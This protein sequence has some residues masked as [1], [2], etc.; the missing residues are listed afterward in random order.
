MEQKNY[1]REDGVINTG[2]WIRYTKNGEPFLNGSLSLG[3][4]DYWVNVF[5]V[6]P[7]NKKSPNSPDR[8]MKLTPKTESI[9]KPV[10]N[11]DS[12]QINDLIGGQDD[13][14]PF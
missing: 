9:Q 6:D 12:T 11:T 3:G 2:L 4:I 13:I 8:T 1:A 7:K 10:I 5:I 14:I